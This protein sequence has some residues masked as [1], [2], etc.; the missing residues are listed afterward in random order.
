[1]TNLRRICRSLVALVLLMALAACQSAEERAQA[2]F[3]RAVELLAEGDFDRAR[4]EFRN[5]F[6]LEGNNRE[7]RLVYAD[8]LRGRGQIDEAYGQFLRVVEQFPDDI[9]GRIALTQMAL[10]LGNLEEAQ[11][12]GPRAMALAP[13]DPR[14]PA[15]EIGLNYFNALAEQDAP[16]SRDI[17]DQVAEMTAATPEGTVLLQRI[18]IIET[19]RNGDVEAMLS[20]ID[21]ALAI[22][23]DQRSLLDLRLAALAELGRMDELE[24]H[25]RDMIARFPQDQELVATLL[26][27]YLSQGDTGQAIAFLR[28][29]ASDATDFERRDE[30][31]MALVQL[32]VDIDGPEAALEEIDRILAETATPPF[33]IELLRASIRFDAGA[34]TVAIAELETLLEADHTPEETAQIRV[35]LARMLLQ[36]DNPVGARAQVEQALEADPDNVDGL[37]IQAA[38]LID[39]DQT[40][41]A[42]GLLRTAVDI[43]PGDVDALTLMAQAHARNGDRDLGR[44]FLLLALE[45]SNAAP[46]PTLRY[47]QELIDQEQFLAAEERLI[48]ALRLA[49]NNPEI[50]FALGTLYI[51]M[52]DWP[53]AEQVEA[54]L[55]NSGEMDLVRRADGMQASRLAAQGRLGEVVSLIESFAAENGTADVQAQLAVIRARLASGDG[56]G[57]LRFAQTLVADNPDALAFRFALAATESATGDLVAAERSFRGLIEDEPQTQQAWIGLIRVLNGLGRPE[58]AEAALQEA[59]SVLPEALDLLWAQATLRERAGDIDGAIEIYEL[60]YD[61]APGAQVVANNLASLLA[62]YRD[63]DESLDRAWTVAR[64]LRGI[65]IAPFQDTYGWIAYRRGDLD[66]ALEHLEPAAQG[67]PDDPIVQYHLGMTY[68]ALERAEDALTQLQFAVDLA[69]P[70]DTRPQFETARDLIAQLQV[71]AET[72]NTE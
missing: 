38:W 17:A 37:K 4:V 30:Y 14:I 7:A 27:F 23:A 43:S 21:T 6:D 67:L 31:L 5:V 62:T 26:R 10:V 32:R 50:L 47:A 11:R 52:E 49:P 2:H 60:M 34:P 48:A 40:D 28:Q 16:A 12:H 19:G 36:T 53:R 41:R 39:E 72:E 1:M 59:L 63:D 56:A 58:D 45:A 3:E 69:G 55:R 24:A 29:G 71:A 9:E 8:A 25:L 35:I 54:T 15:I 70:E 66:A 46:A 42:I 33:L 44:E 13:D 65:E 20:A 61:R 68:L 51:R 57:A 22:D 64:R 18:L